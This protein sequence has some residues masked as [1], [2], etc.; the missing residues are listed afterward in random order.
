MES[1]QLDLGVF[2]LS[3]ER[4][5]PGLSITDVGSEEML[6]VAAK[7]MLSDAGEHVMPGLLR[8]LP[9]VLTPGFLDLLN[10]SVELESVSSDAGSRTNSIHMVRIW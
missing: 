3:S 4:A 7:G 2:T 5:A 1:G 9:L 10:A 6:L 8:S